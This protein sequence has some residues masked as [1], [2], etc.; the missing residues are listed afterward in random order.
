M[1]TTEAIA[2]PLNPILGPQYATILE[3]VNHY[4]YEDPTTSAL[5][6]DLVYASN[7][8]K[9]SDVSYN[10][11]PLG[12]KSTILLGPQIVNGSGLLSITTGVTNNNDTTQFLGFVTVVMS[13]RGI[14][15][16]L[17]SPV[18]LDRTGVGLLLGPIGNGNLFP[19]GFLYSDPP[20]A[21][22]NEIRDT[23][24]HY[25]FP[26]NETYTKKRH[27]AH[28]AG[29]SFSLAAYPAAGAALTKDQHSANNAG[30]MIATKD[31]G[32]SNVAVGYALPPSALCDWVLMVEQAQSEVYEPLDRLR[33]ILLGCIFGTALGMVLLIIPLATVAVKPIEKLRD[34]TLRTVSLSRQHSTASSEEKLGLHSPGE[35]ADEKP[36]GK[37]M[38]FITKAMFWR[39]SNPGIIKPRS[40]RKV[41][42]LPKKVHAGLKL[43]KDGTYHNAPPSASYNAFDADKCDAR[44]DRPPR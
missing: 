11:Q 13:T 2:L 23:Q 15:D 19:R 7:D 22:P 8:N 6:P 20:P 32:R 28:S 31:E 26:P 35:S 21:K 4:N 38:A 34:A 18:G 16:V 43:I 24:V 37:F 27:K 40:R 41:F 1:Y 5:V 33:R 25:M 12:G 3:H 39:R 44:T 14:S 42:R 17:N 36:R 29:Q 9:T 30:S 10:G